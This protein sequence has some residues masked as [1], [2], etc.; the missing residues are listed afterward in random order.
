MSTSSADSPRTDTPLGSIADIGAVVLRGGQMEAIHY[1][2]IAVVDGTG[3]LTH[4][5]GDPSLIT[6]MRS[7][8]KP[9]QLMPLLTSGAADRFAFG[10]RNLSIM[11]GS[12]SGTDEHVAV[13]RENLSRADNDP[14]M[15]KCGTHW[16]IEMQNEQIYPTHGEDRDPLRHNCSGKH[17]GFLALAR[18]LGVGPGMY[19][20]PDTEGQRLVKQAIADW[21]EYAP[22]KMALG[23][24]GCSA[25][26]YPLPLANLAIGFMKLATADN[27]TPAAKAA[28]RIRQAMMNYPVLFSGNNRLDYHFMQS[29]PGRV[30]CKGGAESLQAIGFADPPLGI[31]VKIH[32]GGFRALGA[33]CAET[34]RQLGLT[35]TAAD[36]PLLKSYERPE[37]HNNA[38]LLTGYIVPSF[39]LRKA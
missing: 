38:G 15:L 8:I 39:K 33:I 24:D 30:V 14:G 13:V 10:D 21:C 5:L 11:A 20:D 7:S 18:H 9:F 26:N 16:P 3:K 35:G 25:P 34:F 12:H 4:W 2:S 6:M 31:A 32:D 29:F 22:E 23:I 27:G 19:L 1:A 28:S 36:F 17:S 37:I